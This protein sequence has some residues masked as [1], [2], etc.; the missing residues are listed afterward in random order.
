M[1]F[2][3]N[4][5]MFRRNKLSPFSGLKC[6]QARRRQQACCPED[7]DYFDYMTFMFNV[8]GIFGSKTS[9]IT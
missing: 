8:V 3:K 6:M 2:G 4:Q 1:Y 5:P 7:E 9:T